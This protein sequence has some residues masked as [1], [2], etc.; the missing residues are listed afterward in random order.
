[1]AIK[2]LQL[3]Y[4]LPQFDIPEKYKD[5]T[6]NIKEWDY[7]K[8]MS[9]KEQRVWKARSS[10]TKHILDFTLCKN[11]YIVEEYKY[12]MYFLIEVKKLQLTSFAEYYD[13]YKILSEYVNKH[14]ID[15]TSILELENIDHFEKYLSSDKGNKTVIKK[16]V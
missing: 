9:I 13:R 16:V 12:F 4:P 11:P 14:M 3:Q 2:K 8:N 5:N 1:M 6:W 7:Y 10:K 15:S